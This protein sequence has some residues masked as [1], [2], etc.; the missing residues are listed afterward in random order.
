MPCRV[1]VEQAVAVFG[2][3][4]GDVSL[5]KMEMLQLRNFIWVLVA[6]MKAQPFWAVNRVTNTSLINC[7]TCYLSQA[8]LAWTFG[9]SSVLSG[10]SVSR[11]QR[12]L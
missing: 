11:V 4:R 5:G 7:Y 3:S 2:C 6:Q 12:F 1:G 10:I 8:D 9:R